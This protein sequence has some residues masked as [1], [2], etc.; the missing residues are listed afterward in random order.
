MGQNPQ[1][2]AW[3]RLVFL[4]H[5]LPLSSSSAFEKELTG[6]R[7]MSGL[8]WLPLMVRAKHPSGRMGC[9]PIPLHT[10]GM[11]PEKHYHA[12]NRSYSRIGSPGTPVAFLT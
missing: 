4:S 10:S 1:A 11:H 9:L 3:G 8:Y 12:T 2:G 7:T 6:E 5:Q